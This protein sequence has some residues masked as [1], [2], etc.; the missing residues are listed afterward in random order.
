MR[1]LYGYNYYRFRNSPTMLQPFCDY[2]GEH[3]RF[4][5]SSRNGLSLYEL[6]RRK[7]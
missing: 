1:D 5:K 4:A 3:Y 2:I 6:W 7:P